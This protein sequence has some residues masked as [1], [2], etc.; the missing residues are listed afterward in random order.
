MR[1]EKESGKDLYWIV[2]DVGTAIPCDFKNLIELD[3]EI[4]REIKEKNH[5]EG[6]HE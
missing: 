3:R 4:I 1:V 2:P 6:F 5:R